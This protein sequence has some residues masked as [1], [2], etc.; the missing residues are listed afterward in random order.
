MLFTERV[1]ATPWVFALGCLVWIPVAVWTVSMIGWMVSGDIEVVFGVPALL[2]IFAMG[3]LTTRPPDPLVSPF[4]FT[5]VLGTVIMY[6]V[7][8]RSLEGRAHRR[9]DLELLAG[10]YE[11][12]A[13]KPDNIGPRIRMAEIVAARG[14]YATAVKLLEPCVPSMAGA[15]FAAELKSY[16]MWRTM[17]WDAN[18]Y[19]PVACPACGVR[20]QPGELYCVRCRGPFV[21]DRARVTWLGPSVSRRLLSAWLVGTLVVVGIPAVSKSGW[22]PVVVVGLVLFMM[23]AGL[24]VL[25]KAFGERG[26]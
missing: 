17:A 25:I 24:Y 6:P 21:L 4:L 11:T 5:G 19:D 10:A 12:L 15:V 16:A 23:A 20:N 2:V 13:M 3:F 18:A 26:A 8:R 14:M 9:I 1:M 22:P 7:V